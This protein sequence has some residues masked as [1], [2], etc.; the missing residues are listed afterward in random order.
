MKVLNS[1]GARTET[2]L[3]LDSHLIER[4]TVTE[5]LK[6]LVREM[7]FHFT[8]ISS[9]LLLPTLLTRM[10]DSIRSLTEIK[11]HRPHLLVLPSLHSD[12]PSKKKAWRVETGGDIPS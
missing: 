8:R 11:S 1:N 3:Q 6:L 2:A 9:Y 4:P 5:N 7:C 10:W 12:L